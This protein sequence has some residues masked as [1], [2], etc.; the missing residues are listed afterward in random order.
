M[1]RFTT[2]Y[3]TNFWGVLN[4]NF[5]KT[6]ACFVAIKWVNEA[7]Q[8]IVI[9]IAA[10]AL[11]LPYILL[12]PLADRL[13]ALYDKKSVVRIAK[14][15][16]LP[17]MGVAILG[18]F[19]Q[20]IWVVI[21][22]IVLMGTQSCL[23][24]PSKYGLIR[25]IGGEKNVS[26]GMGGM[27][28][29]AF[30]GMLLGTVAASFLAEEPI[31]ISYGLLLAFAI[32][33]LIGSFTIKADEER[34]TVKYS[35]GPIT[36]FRQSLKVCR[37]YK[38]LEHIIYTLSIFWWMAATIQI[39]MIIYGQ[40]EL[41]LSSFETGL[42]LATA[43]VGITVGCV[44]AGYVD[45]KSTILHLV[46][47]FGIVLAVMFT[48]LFALPWKGWSPIWFTIFLFITT[49]ITGFFKIPLDAEIQKVVK[50]PSL[51]MVL[52][53]FNQISFIFI[54]IASG[55]FALLTILLPIR[56]MF[57]MIAVVMF[58]TGIYIFLNYKSIVCHLFQTFLSLH[59]DVKIENRE[60][61]YSDSVKL[62]MPSHK[63]VADPFI[64]LSTFWDCKL[65]PLVDELYFGN[66]M[67]RHILSLLNSIMVPDVRKNRA[68]M[69]RAKMLNDVTINALKEGNNIMFY[70]SGHIT[71]DG[72][73]T[74]GGRNLAF[75]TSRELPEGVQVLGIRI[76]GL[77]GSKTSR[78]GRK[79]T[80]PLISTFFRYFYK[81]FGPRRKVTLEIE[82]ITERVKLW[83]ADGDKMA[84]NAKLE[85]FYNR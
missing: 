72:K 23:Y 64:M 19:L 48:L 53:F 67:F 25:D 24:S 66:F 7:Y 51:N 76:E 29:I 63:A 37:Q 52:S 54:L 16:E 80:P 30:L 22:A 47:V 69:S 81:F 73:E 28:A 41:G 79:S 8:S 62:V 13:T 39:G 9:S 43:A 10:G 85:E 35:V 68:G 26:T 14:W 12:S 55:S 84:F 82:D 49:I 70:P 83:S 38:G 17:I 65:Q 58:V 40:Q 33:G 74:I 44:I 78:Y 36:F 31:E 6:L 20:N 32:L 3:F 46:P 4:D 61:M 18:F 50:G 34:E 57:L 77:W 11:V 45:R 60:L 71:L 75:S 1:K 21:V 2:L 59:Y 56:Y 42:I 15:V 5:L 27:E